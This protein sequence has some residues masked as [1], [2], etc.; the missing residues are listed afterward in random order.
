MDIAGLIISILALISNV[1]LW[2]VGFIT[3]KQNKRQVDNQ[4]GAMQ[5]DAMAQI[6]Q[7]HQ[8]LFIALLQDENFVRILAND[9]DIDT[10]RSE[11]IGTIL[12]NHCNMIFTYANKSLIEA[13][14]WLGLQN[15]IL[16]FFSWPVVQNRWLKIRPFYSLEFQTFIDNLIQHGRMSSV[17]NSKNMRVQ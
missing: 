13:D 4:V 6:T 16:D 1:L 8:Q 10:Y 5:S 14:D 9:H 12:I 11:M 17:P 3:F 15:D 2:V 7:E